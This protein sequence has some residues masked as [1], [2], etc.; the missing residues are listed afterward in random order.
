MH[1][2]VMKVALGATLLLASF[3]SAQDEASAEEVRTTGWEMRV[4]SDPNNM[5]YSNEQEE[6]FENRIAEILADELGAELTYVW[7]PQRFL[8]VREVFREGECDVVMGVNDGH[9]QFMTTLPYYQSTYVF[10]YKEDSP[11]EIDS[12][13]D[14]DLRELS[15]GVQIGGGEANYIPPAQALANRGLSDNFVGFSIFGDYSQ[16]NPLRPIVAAVE[17]DEIAVATVW[18]PIGGYFAK[19]ASVPLEVVP[20]TPQFE[21][22]FLPMIFS[23]SV[24]VRVGDVDFADQID[25]ALTRRWDDIGAVLA[26]YEIPLIPLPRPSL[27]RRR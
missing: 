8:Q 23:I 1:K 19:E 5:P 17:N 13:D 14:P 21:P 7:T 16:P 18:G 15:I 22:P 2:D 20:V 11:F 4:C 25:L 3:A 12:L 6:G 24:G 9:P 10:V 27:E 26:E